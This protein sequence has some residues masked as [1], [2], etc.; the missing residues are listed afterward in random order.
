MK[1]RFELP[2]L[3][4]VSV[5]CLSSVRAQE[6]TH[7]DEGKAIAAAI[8]GP[9]EKDSRVQSD[10]KPWGINKAT[11]GDPTRPRVLLIGDSI[12]NGYANTVS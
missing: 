5:A 3:L 9:V 11:I 12:L 6:S 4:L 2:A 10:G 7:A 8:N 1:C